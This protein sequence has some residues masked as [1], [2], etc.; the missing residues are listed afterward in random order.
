MPANDLPPV[1][2]YPSLLRLD[3]RVAVV[4]GGGNGMGRE[5]CHA[6]AQAGARVFCVDT[7]ADRAEA[8]AAEAGGE[9]LAADVRRRDAVEELFAEV[10]ERA[11]R[12]DCVVDIVGRANL[13]P[14]ADVDDDGWAEQLDVVLGH[15]FLAMQIGARA[16]ADSGGGAMVFVGSIAGIASLPGQT[17]YGSAKAAL[18]HMVSCMGKELAPSGVR[19]NAVA[20]GFVRT[21]RLEAKLD[22]DG[23]LALGEAIPMGRAAMPAEI[24]SVILFLASDLS[25][26]MTGQALVVDGGL[27]GKVSLPNL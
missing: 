22:E 15:A 26:H 23:W 8:V 2:D 9:G 4:L 21:P 11:G 7:H 18:L 24:A 13:S 10:R 1:P 17:A 25:R 16:I 27:A 12:V 20:P 14:L 6:L 19:V 3:G 5:S